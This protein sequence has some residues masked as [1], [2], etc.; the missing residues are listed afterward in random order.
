MGSGGRMNIKTFII[1]FLLG[2]SCSC[3]MTYEKNF[4]G[5]S[6][7]E[8]ESIPEYGTFQK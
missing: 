3:A 7:K 5:D 1:L 4:G 2:V 6:E 8:E